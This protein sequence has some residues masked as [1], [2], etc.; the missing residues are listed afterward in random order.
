MEE[1]DKYFSEQY[2]TKIQYASI[3]AGIKAHAEDYSFN[4]ESELF[5]QLTKEQQKLWR[6]EIEQACISGGYNGL[7]LGLDKRYDKEEPVSDDLEKAAVEAFKQ[8]VDSDKNNFL[9]IFKAGAKW[10]KTKD[11]STTEDLGEYINELSKQFPEVS[12]AK[13]SRIAV[14]VTKWQK[15]KDAEAINENALLYSARLEGIEIGKA[16]MK[17]QMMVKAIDGDITFDY[18][19]DDDKIYGCIAHN[20]FCLEDFG[21]KDRDK[22]KVIVIKED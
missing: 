7:N 22:V 3:E 13:L 17:Q 16:E 5:N 2:D 18:Y 10:Q 6:K 19:G 1:L 11:E 20:S 9:E 12:F 15:Q 8:I 14:R 21:L 4:I